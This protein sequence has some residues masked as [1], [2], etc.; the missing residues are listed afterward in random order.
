MGRKC[1]NWKRAA[2]FRKN[3]SEPLPLS[4]PPPAHRNGSADHSRLASKCFACTNP[5]HL[6]KGPIRLILYVTISTLLM[7]K[8]RP[9]VVKELL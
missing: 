7:K 1:Y 6:P 2:K 4:S 5:F 8:Q 9:R 3:A